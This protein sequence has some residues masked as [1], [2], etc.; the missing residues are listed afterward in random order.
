MRIQDIQKIFRKAIAP[1]Q[2]KVLLTIGRGI[3]LATKDSDGIQVIQGSFLA[4]ET[5][6]DVEKMHHFG[7]SSHAPK[8]SDCIMVCVGGNRENGIIIATESRQYR[9][10]D[11]G[12]GE[13]ALYSQSGD[14]V[15]L[16][17]GNVIDVK[18]KTLNI[19]ADTEVNITTPTTNISGDVNIGGNEAVEGDVDITG[20]E[21]VG[22]DSTVTGTVTGDIITGV[23]SAGAPSIAAALSLIV[24]GQELNDY[25]NHTHDYNDVGAAVNPQTTGGVN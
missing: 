5:K 3:I 11:L 13:V 2:R 8:G 1:I 20:S 18:T 6:S 4:G 23:T 15:H 25:E 22:G 24:A 16:K 10:K 21:T 12:E 9:F 17:D 7:F 14:F 19:T